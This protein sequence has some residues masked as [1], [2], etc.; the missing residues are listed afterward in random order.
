M[1]KAV[2]MAALA[3]ELGISESAVSKALNDYPDIS[4]ETKKA[5][6]GKAEEM[7]YSPN[8]LARNLA[9]KTSSFV[10]VVIRDVSSVYGEMFKA[11]N[12]SARRRGLNLILYDT[13]YDP[14]IERDAVQ[15]LVDTRAMGIVVVPVS[16]EIGPIREIAGN[17][18]PVVF[19][20]G[21]V[22]ADSV[23]YVCS[24]S[25]AGTQAALEHLTGLGHKKIVMLCD[26]KVS[27][28]RS[29]K[30]AVYREWMRRL[31]QEER[32]LF[33]DAADGDLCEAGKRL[34]RRL[35][36]SGNDFTALFAVKDTLAI[37]AVG[38]L[39]EA[40]VRVPEDVSAVGYDGIDASALPLIGLTT[41]AQPRAEMAEKIMEILCRHAEDPASPPE[42]YLA[43]PGLIIRGSTA[44][45]SPLSPLAGL[46]AEGF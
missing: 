40:G 26:S 10:G 24:D 27:H 1:K 28:S 15:N 11:L 37:G 20:G 44:A 33:S 3:K 18:T 9:K 4:P 29:R 39:R 16:E 42:H 31:G 13:G 14:A 21:K 32:I 30:M 36:D 35:L 38:A 45:P 2:T 7:G 43:R 25:A 6:R 22:R 34:G 41:V 8:L 12:A 17:R 19:L 46:P 5:V 23:N